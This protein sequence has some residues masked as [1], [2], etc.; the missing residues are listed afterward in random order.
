MSYTIVVEFN[1]TAD[2]EY[3]STTQTFTGVFGYLFGE[4]TLSLD[5]RAAATDDAV[6]TVYPWSTITVFTANSETV[7]EGAV[8]ETTEATTEET[9]DESSSE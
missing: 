2:S 3:A 9:T 7:L 8:E 4:T 1:D 5:T 6:W